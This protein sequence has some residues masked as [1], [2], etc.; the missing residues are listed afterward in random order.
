MCA[1]YGPEKLQQFHKKVREKK[2][3][4]VA[5]IALARRMMVII[6]KMLKEEMSFKD[7]HN[8]EMLER[9]KKKYVYEKKRLK[10][11]SKEYGVIEFRRMVRDVLE[12]EQSILTS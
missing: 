11:L 6:W 10:K 3:Y 12:R 7:I 1:R 4:H 5:T 9:K 8:S 2:G